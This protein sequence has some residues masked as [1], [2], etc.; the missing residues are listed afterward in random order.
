MRLADERRCRET[1][2][3]ARFRDGSDDRDFD[4]L[5]RLSRPTLLAWIRRLCAGTGLDPS[6]VLQDTYVNVYRYAGSFRTDSGQTFRAWSRTIAA[7]VIRRHRRPRSLTFQALP[8]S[9]ALEPRDERAGPAGELEVL[10]EEHRMRAAWALFLLHYAVAV[11]QLSP[12][13]REAL[14]LVEV[15]GLTYAEAGQKLQVGVSNMKMIMFRAR[16][17]LRK[18]ISARMSGALEPLERLAG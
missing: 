13:D 16:K 12:R 5:Y 8:A 14:H 18:I 6:E 1:E 2:L 10:E 17:R 11:E 15:D 9:P 4:E 3:M 7:N